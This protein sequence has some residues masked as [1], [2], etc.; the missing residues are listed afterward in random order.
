MNIFI[1][2][3]CAFFNIFKEVGRA[4]VKHKHWTRLNEPVKRPFGFIRFF[5][6]R[7]REGLCLFHL[8]LVGLVIC[9]VYR[10]TKDASVSS[11]M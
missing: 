6:V 5:R 2:R 8:S 11:P 9:L 3:S 7:E 4:T 1:Q 10:C